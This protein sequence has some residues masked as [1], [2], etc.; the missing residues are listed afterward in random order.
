VASRYYVYISD[1]K[2]DMLLSQI[3]PGFGRRITTEAGAGLNLF[4]AKRTVQAPEPDHIARLVRVLR[5]LEEEGLV[6]DVD[7]PAP[8]FRG[9][10]P[11]RWGPLPGGGESTVYFAGR[12]AHTILGLGGSGGH[13]LGPAAPPHAQ[14]AP[15]SLPALLAGLGAA[16]A[17]EAGELPADNEHLGWV[18]TAGRMLRGPLQE[19]EFLARR[20]LTGPSPYPEI[21][22]RTDLRVLLGS[23]LYV[24]LAD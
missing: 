4:N 1:A 22:G 19:V 21:D 17:G 6:G 2:V 14:F 9:R 3:D 12:T 11:M 5:H 10:L 20:L 23:P 16:L 18:H 7:E 24:A 13:V 8:F 15:S